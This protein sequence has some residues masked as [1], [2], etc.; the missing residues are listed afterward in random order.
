[1]ST[2][3][4]TS[5]EL[6]RVIKADP[7]TVFDAWTQPKHMKRWSCPEGLNVADVEVD[8][9][10]GG[11]FRIAMKTPEGDT[12]TAHGVYKAIERPERLVYTWA[13]E[14][15]EESGIGETLVTVEFNDLGGSTEVVLKHEGFPSTEA[16]ADHEKGWASC[17]DRLEKMF[18]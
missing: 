9:K 1:M 14:E 11:R 2:E 15:Q 16:R 5:L 18:S 8:L 13:W 10:V 4:G 7:D 17:L 12:H 3:T 6:T